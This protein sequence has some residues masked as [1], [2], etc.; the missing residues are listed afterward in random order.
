[1]GE[2]RVPLEL[3]LFLT[4]VL[5]LKWR[6]EFHEVSWKVPLVLSAAATLTISAAWYAALR[7]S[8]VVFGLVVITWHDY[9]YNGVRISEK[10]RTQILLSDGR[11]LGAESVHFIDTAFGV[12][13]FLLFLVL[14]SV[15]LKTI[16]AI[17]PRLGRDIRKMLK[18]K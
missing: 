3:S 6:S 15:M 1:M 11:V 18:G 8:N 13:F 14:G 10:Q 12:A 5:C 16:T 4:A 9:V 2:L 17:S 7:I